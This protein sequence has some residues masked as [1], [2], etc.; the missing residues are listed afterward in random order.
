MLW[1]L[2]KRGIPTESEWRLIACDFAERV[3]HLGDEKLNRD[4]IEVA[5]KFARGEATREELGQ[6]YA[7]AAA[8][9]SAAYASAAA[10][11]H[12][13][14]S[15]SAA[16]AAYASASASASAAAYERVMQAEIIRRYFPTINN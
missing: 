11:T 10:Y 4:T 5:R 8:A 13:S 7:S 12:A 3:A 1:L 9:A 2:E 16:A 6:A 15:A 14:A